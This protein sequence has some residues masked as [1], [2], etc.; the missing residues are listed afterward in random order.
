MSNDPPAGPLSGHV[1]LVTGAGRGI[2]RAIAERLA[3]DGAAVAMVARSDDQL[4]EVRG[5]IEAEG[6]QAIACPLDL[7][8]PDAPAQAVTATVA[9]FGS[10]SILVNNAGGAHKL[11]AL[12]RLAEEDFRLVTEL[13]Y[14]SVYRMMREAGPHLF[15]TAAERGP[16][17]VNIVS[18]GAQS[19]L[20][21]MSYYTGAKAAV[22]GLSRTAARE[23]GPRGVRVNCLAPGWIETDLSASLR[24]DPVFTESTLGRTPLGR[25]GTPSDVADAAAFLVS[26]AA[27]F[28]TGTTLLVDGGFLT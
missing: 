25:F 17:V 16:S 11:R 19:A 5:A 6:R 7:L 23:W 21:G 4:Q 20:E 12:D 1:A 27:A 10:L 2:G 9:A 8:D 26:D 3:R 18:I 15:T 13:N 24:A 14:S 22:T 28:V